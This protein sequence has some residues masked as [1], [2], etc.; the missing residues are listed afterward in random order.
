[1]TAPPAIP[2]SSTAPFVTELTL[3]CIS[4]V[5]NYGESRTKTCVRRV[6]AGGWRARLVRF[7]SAE[8]VISG[9]SDARAAPFHDEAC[10]PAFQTATEWIGRTDIATGLPAH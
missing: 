9:E 5:T 6:L 8:A 7:C 2:N 3:G 1:L 10:A 4:S